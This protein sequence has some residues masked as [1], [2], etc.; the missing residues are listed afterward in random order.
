MRA[1]T[2]PILFL[3]TLKVSSAKFGAGD[4]RSN[5]HVEAVGGRSVG[6]KVRNQQATVDFLRDFGRDAVALVAHHDETVRRERFGVDVVAVEQG[7]IDGK[8]VWQRVDERR[9][10]LID[11]FHA[12]EASHRRLHHLRGVGIGGVGTA[13]NGL[14]AEPVGNADDGAEVARV[15]DAVES[16]RQLRVES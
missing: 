4:G 2:V 14:D 12:G 5:R 9:E 15:L 3:S 6:G 13:E 1:K 10:V 11:D 8:I 16:E 7:A